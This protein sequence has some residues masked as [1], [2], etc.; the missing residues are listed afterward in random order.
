MNGKHVLTIFLTALSAALAPIQQYAIAMPTWAHALILA[1]L[2]AVAVLMPGLSVYTV[3]I[4]GEITPQRK[5]VEIPPSPA[6]TVAPA[7]V[8]TPAPPAVS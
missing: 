1:V 7:P 3:Q 6:A 5:P 8:I 4:A 2:G